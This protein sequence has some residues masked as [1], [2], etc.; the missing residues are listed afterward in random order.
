MGF[1]FQHKIKKHN[2]FPKL[3][4]SFFKKSLNDPSG[5]IL[6]E[7]PGLLETCTKNVNAMT[8]G[9]CFSW[10]WAELDEET[11]VTGTTYKYYN[12]N[13]DMSCRKKKP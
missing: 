2:Q 11:D 12:N 9:F 8:L 5:L 4:S 6:G 1:H 13:S 10:W 7:K 3:L